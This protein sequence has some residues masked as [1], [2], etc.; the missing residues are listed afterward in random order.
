MKRHVYSIKGFRSKR[1]ILLTAGLLCVFIC[2]FTSGG[3][4]RAAGRE[5]SFSL[6]EKTLT[7]IVSALT[8]DFIAIVYNVDKNT[9]AEYEMPFS[10]PA[11]IKLSRASSLSNI[12]LGDTVE[13]LYQEKLMDVEVKRADGKAAIE[14]HIVHRELKNITYIKSASTAMMSGNESDLDRRYRARQEY[15]QGLDIK[16]SAKEYLDKLEQS[17]RQAQGRDK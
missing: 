3:Y 9:Q 15:D 14:R 6:T 10:I 8:A 1:N 7:G 17:Q 4:A 16:G 5:G 2:L 12:S 11:D 13:V